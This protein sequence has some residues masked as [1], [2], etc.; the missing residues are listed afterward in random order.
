MTT[1]HVV[2]S[3]HLLAMQLEALLSKVEPN[4]NDW[5]TQDDGR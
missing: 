3:I 2:L 5:K 1:K 4:D